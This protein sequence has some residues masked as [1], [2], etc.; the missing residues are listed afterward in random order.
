VTPT[1]GRR[2]RSATTAHA[3]GVGEGWG[4]GAGC[5]G[6][7]KSTPAVRSRLGLATWMPLRSSQRTHAGL[8]LPIPA[9]ELVRR[10]GVRVAVH[11]E[12][13]NSVDSATRLPLGH[14]GL[15]RCEVDPHKV[16]RLVKPATH[17]GVTPRRHDEVRISERASAGNG[18]VL[19]VVG[20]RRVE[21]RGSGA[22]LAQACPGAGRPK[23]AHRAGVRIREG[24]GRERPGGRDQTS[25]VCTV[26]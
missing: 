26:V 9:I 2:R 13:V 6:D 20:A 8:Q 21:V 23:H 1:A 16:E 7:V 24:V 15:I 5:D 11:M 4:G 10:E 18:A 17:G 25:A 14:C 19:D 12:A 3:D 22:P